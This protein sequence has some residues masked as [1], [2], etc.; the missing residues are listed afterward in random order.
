MSILT[1]RLE[2][3][4][5]TP[6]VIGGAAVE[7]YTRDWYSTG[8]IDLAI[9][10]RKRDEFHE[11]MEEFDFEKEGRMWTREDLNLYVEIP[12]DINDIDEERLTEV[13]TEA[14]RTYVIGLE[15]II[16]DRIQAAEHWESKSDREQAVRMGASFYDEIDWDHVRKRCKKELSEEMLDEVLEEI[17]DE[18][19]KA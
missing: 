1:E 6:V 18:K 13:E 7:F 11:V 12:G 14:G 19:D 9:D 8:D 16:F 2:E 3:K 15:D 10:K 5:I 17:E 4:G